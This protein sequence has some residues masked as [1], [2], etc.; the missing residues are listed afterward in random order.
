MAGRAQSPLRT[1]LR[2]P[3]QVK[4]QSTESS[5]SEES[6]ESDDNDLAQRCERGLEQDARPETTVAPRL[7]STTQV[8]SQVTRQTHEQLKQLAEAVLEHGRVLE[9]ARQERA[10]QRAEDDALLQKLRSNEDAEQL[11]RRRSEDEAL[12]LRRINEDEDTRKRRRLEDARIHDMRRSED[13]M[14]C[15]LRLANLFKEADDNAV[16]GR[17]KRQHAELLRLAA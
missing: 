13:R 9:R 8:L 7:V 6:A 4:E 14:H 5:G 15:P 12:Q 16:I 10:T 2:S 17:L 1:G 11:L 3:L